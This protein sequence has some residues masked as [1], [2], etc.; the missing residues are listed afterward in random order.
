[1]PSMC[2]RGRHKAPNRAGAEGGCIRGLAEHHQRRY[3]APGDVH[4]PQTAWSSCMHGIYNKVLSMTALIYTPLLCPDTIRVPC[5]R[6]EVK[7]MDRLVCW[8][9]HHLRDESPSAAMRQAI[10]QNHTSPNGPVW[11][12]FFFLFSQWVECQSCPQPPPSKF[13]DLL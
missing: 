3:S 9:T 10:P 1:M 11:V 13:E 12:L 5:N 7:S 4:K 6:G 2:H 8:C